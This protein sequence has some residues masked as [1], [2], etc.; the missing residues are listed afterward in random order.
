VERLGVERT[1]QQASR[2]ELILLMMDGSGPLQEGDRLLMKEVAHRRVIVI[3]N[4]GDLPQ[5]TF[6]EDIKA[7]LPEA[8]ILKVS[9]KA[10][11]GL[12]ELKKAIYDEA[13]GQSLEGVMVASLRHATALEE[14]LAA[15]KEAKEALAEGLSEELICI[16]VRAGLTALGKITGES[17][18]Q[19]LLDE[20][21]S[22]FCIGK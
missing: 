1:R 15:V 6:P 22:R 9:L 16:D 18:D 11:W 21:F 8:P 4:K 5:R 13:V 14:A 19:D 2:A 17:V 7:H 12:D 10:G 20:I 3:L